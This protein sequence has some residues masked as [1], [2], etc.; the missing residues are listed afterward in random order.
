MPG[1]FTPLRLR[2]VS[3]DN[4][5]VVAPM[6]QYQATDGSASDW[7]LIH[8]G[9]LAAS[10]AGLVLTESA[11]VEPQGRITTGCLGLYSDDNEAALRRVFDACRRYGSARLG[12]QL[13]HAGRKG[14]ARLPWRGRNQPLATSEGGWRTW[15]CAGQPRAPGWPTPSVLDAEGLRRVRDAHTGAARRASRIG[16]DLLELTMA[17][18]YLLHEFLSPLSNVREDGY[19]GDLHG[20]MRYPLEVFEAIRDVWPTDRA[21]GVRISAT[22]HLPD[23]W[24]LEGSV[25]L[26]SALQDRGCDYISV[27]SGG[28]SLDQQIPLGEAHQVPYAATIREQVGIAT[29]A[30]GMIYDP[31]AAD[32]IVV[33]GAADLIALARAFLWDPRWPWFAAAELDAEVEHPQAYLRGY[34]SRWHRDQR[35]GSGSRGTPPG[36][37][38]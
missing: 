27:S 10:G 3:L 9:T 37:A 2:D 35:L 19:G 31:R 38:P 11:H 6:A 7:H 12:I 28:L 8:L 16:A 20:R 26:A 21:L 15:S 23:G 36:S 14:S 24:D 30:A 22:D 25:T 32:R 29:M 4:R 34:R 33:D 1:L 5:I 17:H 18:G 13:S